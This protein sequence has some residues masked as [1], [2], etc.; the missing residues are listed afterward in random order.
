MKK[1]LLILL[2]TSAVFSAQ[3][4]LTK[5]SNDPISGDVV[6]YNAVNGTVDNSAL[7]ANVTFSNGSLTMGAASQTTY[8][9]PT[10]TEIST[11]PGTTIKMADG[12]TTI[13]YKASATKLEITGIVNPQATLNFSV[14]NG[15]YNNYPTAYGPAQ[16][17]NAKGTFSSSVANGLFS[18]TLSTQADA[19]GT[20]IVGN[21]TYS[22][23]LRVKY[24]QNFNL[25]ASFDIAYSNPIGAVTNTAY[26]YYDAS[27]RYA[28]LNTTNG[29]ISVP[30]LGINQS[31]SSA[32]ALSETFLAI[33]NAVK[34]ENLTVYPNPA[35]DFIG[36]KGNTE[37][38]TKANIYSL[39][40]KLIKTSDMKS[41][42]I[43]ISDLPPASY[44]IEVSGK[45]AGD[46]KNTK[47]IKK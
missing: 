9:A 28:L 3:I 20:L 1:T 34:K 29:N 31:T 27:H 8:S 30:L 32:Q 37:N 5:A 24:T 13:Y 47:F 40:G 46:S 43:Q 23:V 39:D 26:A 10:S 22:N 2:G 35:Q 33:S 14:D 38:Y 12:T 4:T 42:N 15:T 36:F 25:Y 16:N 18:G 19:Y 41:G 17:D 11:F 21:Q 6:N 7:G 44:F 45:N